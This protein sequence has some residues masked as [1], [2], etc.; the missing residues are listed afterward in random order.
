[1]L[2]PFIAVG[3]ALNL[4]GAYLLHRQTASWRLISKLTV[5]TADFYI[6]LVGLLV[7]LPLTHS[8]YGRV[9]PVAIVFSVIYLTLQGFILLFF[10]G[11]LRLFKRLRSRRKERWLWSSYAFF[12][13]AILS[14]LFYAFFIE[15]FWLDVT[16]H[17]IITR[18][19]APGT[20]AIKIV[21]ISDIHIERWT[22]RE[23]ATIQII[24]SLHPDLLFLT[25]DFINIDYYEPQAYTDLH[26]FFSQLH[27]KYGVYAV[28]GVVDNYMGT[29][30]QLPGTSVQLL[31]NT[32]RKLVINNQA[33][34]L[35]GVNSTDS[36]LKWDAY[37]LQ[38]ASANIPPQALKLLLYHTPDLAPQAAA[39]S[40]DFYFAGHT[41]GGQIDLPFYGAVFTSSIF[42]RKYTSGLFNIGNGSQM[43]VNRGLGFEG[44]NTPR[45]RFLARPEISVF[46]LMP[47]NS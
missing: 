47:A 9:K 13:L 12:Q 27:A 29:R 40:F 14:L 37:Q 42:G 1:M 23:T 30:L 46:N 32:Q 25:G 38:Q 28:Q 20:P 44:L 21:Q 43:Y 8:S 39:A 18:K 15:P 19:L 45:A 22:R 34:Y 5:V 4:G 26:R 10:A 2:W 6:L 17:Q 41:H 7:L 36:N 24:N 16:Y 31:E 35:V 11:M 33:I 3:L